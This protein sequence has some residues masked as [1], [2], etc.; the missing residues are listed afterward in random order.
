[1][2][3]VYGVETKSYRN[4]DWEEQLPRIRLAKVAL[5]ILGSEWV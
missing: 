2:R 3:A 4:V 5:G 1:M